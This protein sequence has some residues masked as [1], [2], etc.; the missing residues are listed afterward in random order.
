M[1]VDVPVSALTPRAQ[2]AIVALYREYKS[3]VAFADYITPPRGYYA[4][5]SREY[6]EKLREIVRHGMR[7]TP[8]DRMVRI[9]C[10]QCG[11]CNTIPG[12]VQRWKCVCSPHTERYV[13]QAIT[14]D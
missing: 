8:N 6:E 14:E 7:E 5:L 4:Q 10:P 11:R 1:P 2:K 13:F 9:K 12:D 3:K